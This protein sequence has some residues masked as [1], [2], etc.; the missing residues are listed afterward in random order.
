MYYGYDSW[1]ELI[2]N[3]NSGIWGLLSIVIP[4]LVGIAFMDGPKKKKRAG[5]PANNKK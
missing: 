3:P 1:L 5:K 4:I 2:F